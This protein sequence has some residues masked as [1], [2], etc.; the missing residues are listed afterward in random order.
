MVTSARCR[1]RL[2]VDSAVEAEPRDAKYPAPC[3]PR[4]AEP[5]AVCSMLVVV[6][7]AMVVVV[8]VVVLAD[9]PASLAH[10]RRLSLRGL[11]E[12]SIKPLAVIIASPT[13]TPAA[14]DDDKSADKPAGTAA[15]KSA[16]K[17]AGTAAP[18]AR[19]TASYTS[20]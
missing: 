11:R 8:V 2:T 3:V 4:D 16:D 9:G 20:L 17:P 12:L 14:A 1:S 6:A 7:V 13:M 18:C 5:R 19:P 15:D 10:F